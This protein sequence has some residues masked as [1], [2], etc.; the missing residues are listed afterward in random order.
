MYVQCY[1]AVLCLVVTDTVMMMSSYSDAVVIRHPQPGA[2]GVSVVVVSDN[3]VI[4]CTSTDNCKCVVLQAYIVLATC[5]VI[6]DCSAVY[7]TE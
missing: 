3:S 2:V 7:L 6:T 1:N 5:C 4:K